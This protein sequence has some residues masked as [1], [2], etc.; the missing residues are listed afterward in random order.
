MMA[1]R[2]WPTELCHHKESPSLRFRFLLLGP[3]ASPCISCSRPPEDLFTFGPE[4][5]LEEVGDN[6]SMPELLREEENEDETKDDS[7]AGSVNGGQFSDI[8][9]MN[10]N[11]FK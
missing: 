7:I 3:D 6:L 2:I 1:K 5:D 11:A 8:K 4:L 10:L 9:L